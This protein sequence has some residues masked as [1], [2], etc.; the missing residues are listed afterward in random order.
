MKRKVAHQL[1]I[2]QDN[3]M[4]YAQYRTYA[5]TTSQIGTADM[6]V[7]A[8]NVETAAK[9]AI[10]MESKT[11]DEVPIEIEC[12]AEMKS[13]AEVAA[14][15]PATTTA[16]AAPKAND[17][18]QIIVNDTRK[19]FKEMRPFVPLLNKENNGEFVDK[20]DQQQIM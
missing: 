18:P 6:W 13:A 7:E 10:S 15:A 8:Y 3:I 4:Q 14:A 1:I 17:K 9:I 11:G 5:A 19:P 20:V 2:V 16:V 12:I